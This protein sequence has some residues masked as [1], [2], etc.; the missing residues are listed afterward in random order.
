MSYVIRAATRAD[1]VTIAPLLR[2]KDRIELET[3]SGLSPGVVLPRAFDVPGHRAIFAETESGE[4]ILIA[5]T[6]PTAPN[7][8][9][10]WM[11][12][13]PLLEQ[14]PKAFIAEGREWLE[15]Q[16]K[17]YPMLWNRA[18]AGNLL[19]V[20]W[21]RFMGFKVLEAQEVQGKRFIGFARIR[22]V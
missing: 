21:L 16:H 14:F 18:W 20:R 19:H 8:G 1:A 2:E 22:N 17:T 13:T 15:E 12:A 6:S 9:C 3:A 7:I 5:G 10:I 11:V 4:P